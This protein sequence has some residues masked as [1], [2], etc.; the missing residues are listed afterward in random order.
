[1]RGISSNVMCGQEGLFGTSAFQTFLDI[2]QMN[3]LDAKYN[4]TYTDVDAEISNA[5]GNM[6]IEDTKDKCSKSNIEIKSQ[7]DKVSILDSGCTD[8]NYDPFA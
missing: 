3:T 4:Y 2:E 6:S 7:L 1:M 8:D 5:F